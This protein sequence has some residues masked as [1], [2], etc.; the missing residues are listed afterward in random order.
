MLTAEA[1]PARCALMQ[2]RRMGE[3]TQRRLRWALQDEFLMG[4]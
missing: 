3:R 1:R 4:H 2:H